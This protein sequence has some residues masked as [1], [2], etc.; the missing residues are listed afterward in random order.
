ML[1]DFSSM[2]RTAKRP[3][4]C[5]IDLRAVLCSSFQ[6]KLGAFQ[7]SAFIRHSVFLLKAITWG[8]GKLHMVISLENSAKPFDRTMNIL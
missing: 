5:A 2:D 6:E 3:T 7:V 1:T 4:A 8:A